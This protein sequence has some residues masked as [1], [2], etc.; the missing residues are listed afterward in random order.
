[1]DGWTD[2]QTDGWMDGPTADGWAY[3][4]MDVA[5]FIWRCEDASVKRRNEAEG[6]IKKC[7]EDEKTKKEGKLG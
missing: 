6:I 5:S 1:M 7:E 3:Q 2:R 4:R